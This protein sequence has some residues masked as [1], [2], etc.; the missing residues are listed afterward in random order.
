V[1]DH[2]ALAAG[3]AVVRG[4]RVGIAALEEGQQA[5]LAAAEHSQMDPSLGEEHFGMV[6]SAALHFGMDH[7]AVVHFGTD[8]SA[9]GHFGRDDFGAGHFGIGHSGG[10]NSGR[11]PTGREAGRRLQPEAEGSRYRPGRAEIIC[12]YLKKNILQRSDMLAQY[13]RRD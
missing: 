13:K 9:T 10:G 12:N 6:H 3:V 5:L 1:A 11:D 7:S 4:P 8:H 2:W